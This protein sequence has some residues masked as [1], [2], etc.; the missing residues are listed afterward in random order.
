MPLYSIDNVIGQIAIYN[1][2]SPLI[3]PN[4]INPEGFFFKGHNSNSG[5]GY[6]FVMRSGSTKTSAITLDAGELIY[7]PVTNLNM[8]AFD[9]DS[10]STVIC[11]V[12][13]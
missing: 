6:A 1:T 4:V 8:L 12:R 7:V 11:Y 5:S 9:A 13:A 10:G 3:G 2:G